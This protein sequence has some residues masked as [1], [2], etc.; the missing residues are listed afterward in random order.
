MKKIIKITIFYLIFI[1]VSVLETTIPI[2]VPVV[3]YAHGLGSSAPKLKTG[4]IDKI[5][6]DYLSYGNTGPETVNDKF[7]RRKAVFA[8]E[9]D[10]VQVIAAC[11]EALKNHE[12]PEIIAFG[13]S[14]G[15]ATWINTLAYLNKSIIPGH[16]K[17]LSC[18]KAVILLAPFADPFEPEILAGL[19]RTLKPVVKRLTLPKFFWLGRISM[20]HLVKSLCPDYDPKGIQPITSVKDIS[21]DIPIFIAHSQGDEIIPVNHSRMLYGELIRNLER[22]SNKNTYLFE[23]RGAG[24]RASK[25]DCT[26]WYEPMCEFLN[27]YHLMPN[28]ESKKDKFYLDF[29][30]PTESFIKCVIKGSSPLPS[31]A[32]GLIAACGLETYKYFKHKKVSQ[33]KYRFTFKRS[34]AYGAAI[35]AASE[36]IYLCNKKTSLC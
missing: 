20:E 25:N 32:Y 3:V 33:E 7:D 1:D 21:M 19:F 2:K 27:K 31:L 23:F 6:P 29:Y 24:H 8:Q 35:A 36:L 18:I 14:K 28:F 30:Q 22:D 15:A 10:I 13:F 4:L 26:L 34:L 11:E 5:F 16:K 9:A 12:T 17:I